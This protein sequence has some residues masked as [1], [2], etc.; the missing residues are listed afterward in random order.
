MKF[1][2]P[3]L[4]LLVIVNA[5]S[6]SIE[7]LGDQTGEP[8]VLEITGPDSIA[9]GNCSGPFSAKLQDLEGN[10]KSLGSDTLVS[11]GGISAE[12]IFS[13]ERCTQVLSELKVA[14]DATETSFYIQVTPLS[15]CVAS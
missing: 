12:A 7:E 6:F 4:I 11:I 15:A 3:Y 8:I 14:K 1:L 13:D 10:P 9:S 2:A 5:C